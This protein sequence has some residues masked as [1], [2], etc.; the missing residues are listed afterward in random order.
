[1]KRPCDGM[2][3]PIVATAGEARVGELAAHLARCVACAGYA[4]SI[5]RSALA[6]RSLPRDEPSEAL[7]GLVV[8]AFH[9]GHRQERAVDA[10]R[11]LTREPTPS[12]LDQRLWKRGPRAAPTVLDRLVAEELADP[13][14]AISKRYAGSLQRLSAPDELRRRIATAN[15]HRPARLAAWSTAALVFV[16]VGLVSIV[17]WFGSRTVGDGLVDV[18]VEHVT[19]TDEL[20]P[21]SARLFAGFAGPSVD[22]DRALRRQK[23]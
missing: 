15:S 22:V 7:D 9:A 20:S 11:A 8:A 19:T 5:D 2:R 3:D 12:A 13:E 14:K 4:A 1:M 23:P 16:V 21:L 18:T 10:V 17:Q 6:L